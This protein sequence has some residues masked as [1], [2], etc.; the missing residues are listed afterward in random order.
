MDQQRRVILFVSLSMAVWIAYATFVLPHFMP[1]RP[2]AAK[3]DVDAAE[4]TDGPVSALFPLNVVPEMAADEQ[5]DPQAPA[6][7]AHPAK[8]VELGSSDPKSGYFVHVALS[9]RGAAVESV[10]LNDERYPEFGKR[11]TPLQLV[12]HDPS[13][14]QKTFA[15]QAPTLDPHLGGQPADVIPWEVV[16]AETTPSAATFRLVTADGKFELRKRYEIE[17]APADKALDNQLRDTWVD[18]YRLKL[19]ITAK[20]LARGETKFSYMLR[21]PAA[22]PLEDAANTYKFRDI[23]LG[24]L[25]TG[26]GV[27]PSQFSAKTAVQEAK[28]NAPSKWQR[29][30]SYIG[31][32]TQYFAAIL[33]PAVAATVASSEAEVLKTGRNDSHADLSVILTSSPITLAAAGAADNSNEIVHEYSLFSMPK[34]Q[35]LL[36]ALNAE[37]VLDYGWFRPIVLLMLWIFNTL[38]AIGFS[39][40]FAIIGLT[41][42]IRCLL[43][44]LTRRQMRTM[45]GMKQHQ[46]ELKILHEKMKKDPE[47]LTLEERQKMQSIQ[48]K[49][50]GGCLP[51]LLQMPIFIA[52]YRALQVSVDL[53]MAPMHI[54]GNWIDNLASPD[55][56]FAFGF[57]IPWLEWNEFNLLPLLSTAL[58]IVNQKLTMPPPVDEEQR[59][60]QKTMNFTMA[61]M[62]AMF[63]RVPSGLCIYIITSSAWGMIERALLKKFS[64]GTDTPPGT[65]GTLIPAGNPG[66]GGPTGNGKPPAPSDK[67]GMFDG[68]KQK[69]RELQEMADKQAAVTREA[70]S[71]ANPPRGKNKGKG[72]K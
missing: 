49:M 21:G 3:I 47:S 32:D 28:K 5:P 68:I 7:V 26:G 67:P 50:M 55:R 45:E 34:R 31:I 22:L 27:D 57:S 40:G 8:T 56:L 16:D 59:I 54:F 63:Y 64:P 14:L 72:R 44:P 70:S 9:S 52:L 23:R 35:A 58:M 18:G 24:F 19:T 38:H 37:A 71:A 6:M 2:Q 46:P 25:R 12:G 62:G 66:S 69:M 60:Q 13:I 36:E 15:M 48:L 41:I 30:L 65:E 39:Y 61:I 17:K 11:G 33:Q 42:I 10:T 53:R 4:L 20:N 1:P 29:P 51:L 43:Y